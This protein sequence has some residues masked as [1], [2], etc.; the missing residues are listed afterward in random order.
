MMIEMDR[1]VYT[2]E[3]KEKESIWRPSIH[4]AATMKDH[5]PTIKGT[6]AEIKNL[7]SHGTWCG[8]P[9]NMF[10]PKL[11]YR[12]NFIQKQNLSSIFN[13]EVEISC[14]EMS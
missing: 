12:N 9:Q 4:S 14:W 13:L 8:I 7:T 2:L 10:L 1:F 3:G 5:G 11:V 6:M